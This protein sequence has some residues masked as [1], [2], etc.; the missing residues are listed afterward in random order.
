MPAPPDRQD[1]RLEGCIAPFPSMKA[2][3]GERAQTRDSQGE[4]DMRHETVFQ[5]ESVFMK[6]GR[7][8]SSRARACLS[9]LS[10]FLPPTLLHYSS[11]VY[12]PE[13]P[14]SSI[15]VLVYSFWFHPSLLFCRNHIHPFKGRQKRG[16]GEASSTESGIK[17]VFCLFSLPTPAF[18]R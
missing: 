18:H 1:H 10:H 17:L 16:R 13:I 8:A 6:D 9:C 7:R 12:S 3:D 11:L 14:V 4:G 5:A 2:F 15:S